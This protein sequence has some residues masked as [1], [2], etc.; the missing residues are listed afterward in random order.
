MADPPTSFTNNLLDSSLTKPFVGLEYL[1]QDCTNLGLGL[2]GRTIRWMR[3][4]CSRRSW[5]TTSPA[6]SPANSG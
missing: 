5:N 4:P 2:G 1:G 6:A 3:R